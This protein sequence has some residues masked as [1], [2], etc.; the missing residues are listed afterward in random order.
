MLAWP[1]SERK[2]G[3]RKLY[4][5]IIH[6][7]TGI[8]T[9]ILSLSQVSLV[10]GDWTNQENYLTKEKQQHTRNFNTWDHEQDALLGTTSYTREQSTA[11]EPYDLLGGRRCSFHSRLFARCEPNIIVSN[12]L[13]SA[14]TISLHMKATYLLGWS[15]RI[16][17]TLV[18]GVEVSNIVT[19]SSPGGERPVLPANSVSLEYFVDH[20]DETLHHRALVVLSFY[21]E[22]ERERER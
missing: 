11:P 7:I 15:D 21:A 12:R 2:L 6:R 19:L 18:I 17:V 10:A 13:V 20:G 16:Y 3:M 14:V 9:R 4:I 22:G 8:K 1:D 5:I